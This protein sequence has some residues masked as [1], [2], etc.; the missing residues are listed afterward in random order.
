MHLGVIHKSG[1]S[2]IVEIQ[3]YGDGVS[4]IT[5]PRGLVDA[6]LG[7]E[8]SAPDDNFF[9]LINGREVDFKENPPNNVSRSL[10][11][12]FSKGA[13]TREIIETFLISCCE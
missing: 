1:S 2:L 11:I 3:S 10:S 5:I 9:V 12:P 13:N 6:K 7:N 8:E 4:S